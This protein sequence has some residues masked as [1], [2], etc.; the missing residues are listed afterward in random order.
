MYLLILQKHLNLF[1]HNNLFLNLKDLYVGSDANISLK[2]SDDVSIKSAKLFYKFE[3]DTDFK[4]KVWG[5]AA[6]DSLITK[7][8]GFFNK[9]KEAK[10]RKNSEPTATPTPELEQPKSTPEL[11]SEPE[12]TLETPD[13]SMSYEELFDQKVNSIL[14]DLDE[15]D[16][17]KQAASENNQNLPNISGEE[18]NI[19]PEQS[20]G[21]R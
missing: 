13:N 3:N 21:G 7:G 19:E 4:E 11:N 15:N 1:L 10:E 12:E 9:L 5:L 8:K 16:R 2:I 6:I 14:N 20:L 18:Y 17:K